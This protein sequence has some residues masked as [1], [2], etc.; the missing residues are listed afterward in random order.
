[1][2]LLTHSHNVTK[3]HKHAKNTNKKIIKKIKNPLI[4]HP[5]N[6]I[7]TQKD[8]YGVC[9]ERLFYFLFINKIHL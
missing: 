5:I 4:T 7:N 8:T 9:D 6:K 2:L 1:M 3:K